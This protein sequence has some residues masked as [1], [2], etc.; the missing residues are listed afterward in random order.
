M[1]F[2][3]HGKASFFGLILLLI[4]SFQETYAQSFYN[5][6]RDR[7]LMVGIGLGTTNYY[8]D[9]RNT[10][11]VLNFNTNVALNVEYPVSPHLNIRGEFMLYQIAAS[12]NDYTGDDSPES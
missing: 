10:G 1:Y 6:K 7:K 11:Q 9:L 3:M 4:L 2:F 5:W 12:D 8:G